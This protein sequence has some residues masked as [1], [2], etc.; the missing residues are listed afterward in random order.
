MLVCGPSRDCTLLHALRRE[1]TL[2]RGPNRECIL[3]E[4]SVRGWSSGCLPGRCWRG[5]LSALVLLRNISSGVRCISVHCKSRFTKVVC[6]A[7]TL[8]NSMTCRDKCCSP[9]GLEELG[10]NMPPWAMEEW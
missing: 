8:V 9:F 7:R 3:P 2:S 5:S 10:R 1:Y 4:H 6:C